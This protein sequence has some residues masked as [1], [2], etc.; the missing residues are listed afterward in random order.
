MYCC[1][2][3]SRHSKKKRK[4]CSEIPG[5]LLLHTT[6][7]GGRTS[8]HSGY[9]GDN[10]PATNNKCFFIAEFFFCFY[11][12]LS[13]NRIDKHQHNT[14]KQHCNSYCNRALQHFVYFLTE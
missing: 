5:K 13:K 10:L 6:N 11:C 12:R 14:T 1:S 2:K 7:N 8:A 4:F 3:H 9:H